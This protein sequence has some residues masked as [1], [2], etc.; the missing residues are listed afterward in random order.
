MTTKTL[1]LGLMAATAAAPLAAQS[2]GGPRPRVEVWTNRG[3]D[4]VARGDRVRVFLRADRDAFVTVFRVDTDGRVRVLFPRE[5]WEDTFVRREREYEIEG[6]GGRFAFSVDD[7]PGVGYVFAVVAADPFDYRAVVAGDHWDYRTI[8][9]GRVRGD[10]YVAL[11]DLAQRIVAEG[12]EDWDYDLVP[13]HVE[14]HYDYPRFV[15][16]DCHAYASWTYWNPYA[17]SCWQ[18]RIVIYDDPWYYPYRYYGGTRVVWVRPYR[19]PPRYVFKEWNAVSRDRDPF[20]T[21]VR[22]RPVTDGR[23]RVARGSRFDPGSIPAPRTR[24]RDRPRGDDDDRPN[25]PDR[26]DD[27]RR[28]DRP[29]RPDQPDRPNRPDRPDQSDRP[30]R[31]DQPSRS[32]RPEQ[33]SRPDRGARS[34]LQDRGS[35]GVASPGRGSPEIG[36]RAEPS[37]RRD[38]PSASLRRVPDDARGATA[39]GS[40]AK[41]AE[42]GGSPPSPAA[43]PAPSARGSGSR[44][45]ARGTA[46]APSVSRAPSRGSG[47]RAAPR[48]STPKLKRRSD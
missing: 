47:S 5:P 23:E 41:G 20:I 30:N 46:R 27:R 29:D 38:A 14:R 2:R 45:T 32:Q 10:P 16:Y 33:P 17:Y 31:P 28:P 18:F 13:Y 15:C 4:V 6:P 12:Y 3:D 11:T 48:K 25:R 26:P 8:A 34:S 37:S 44:S 42:R 40:T 36:R 22:Q 35:S 9:D 24:D 1:L 7:Y 43:R 39:R 19:P 21:R